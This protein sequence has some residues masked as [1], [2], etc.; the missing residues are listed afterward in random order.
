MCKAEERA[1]YRKTK[2]GFL[3]RLYNNML[4][5][6]SG[7]VPKG[8]EHYEGLMILP[9]ADLYEWALASPE[10]HELFA[11]WEESGYQMRLTPSL[12]RINSDRGYTLDNI[13][14]L[15]HSENSRLGA[16]SDK[17]KKLTNVG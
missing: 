9:R 12:N 1:R 8:R 2:K 16:V 15:T 14:W 5:R 10:F 4:S 7:Q 3:V 11:Q 17:R 6:V 13:E